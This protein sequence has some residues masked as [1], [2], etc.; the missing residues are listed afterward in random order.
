M[1]P[2]QLLTIKELAATLGRS[3]TYVA[4]MKRAGFMMPG[5]QATLSEARA[6]LARNPP[7]R[8]RKLFLSK[9]A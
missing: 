4:A 8:S 9:A 5:G 6:W 3:R 2:E 1:N 7:P